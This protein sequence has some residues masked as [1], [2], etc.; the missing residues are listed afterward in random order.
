VRSLA[1]AAFVAAVALFALAWWQFVFVGTDHPRRADVIVVL[2]GNLR[3]PAT[4]L[5]LLHDHVAPLLM[6]SVAPNPE[7]PI[8]AL[9]GRPEVRCFHASTYSTRGEARTVA[10]LA[11]RHGWHS[12]VIVSSRY[13]LRRAHMLFRRCTK[14]ALQMVPSSTTLWDYVTN[15]PLE[16][17]KLAVQFTA[18][19]GC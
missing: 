14:A 4:G 16:V 1:I 12:I 3:R 5:K 17:G 18:E 15:A 11:R 19:R 7:P 8:A 2:S 6:L 13:H 10:K 9:C